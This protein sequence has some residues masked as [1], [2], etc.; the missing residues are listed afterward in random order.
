LLDH[1]VLEFAASLPDHF[2]IQGGDTKRVL[3][4]ALRQQVPQEIVERKKAGFPVPYEGWLRTD[5]RE[6]VS[7]TI[8]G[9]GTG[10]A[11]YFDHAA[12]SRFVTHALDHGG[13]AKEI[14]SLVVL[15]LWHRQFLTGVAT[16][17]PVEDRQPAWIAHE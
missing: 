1:Q 4:A 2:K 10:L 13:H 16:P 11:Q 5:L 12:L 9:S 3:K 6:F 8:L 14:F 15:E 7:D 17:S